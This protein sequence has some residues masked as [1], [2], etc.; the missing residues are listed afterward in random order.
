MPGFTHSSA[1]PIQT[2]SSPPRLLLLRPRPRAIQL[3]TSALGL[4]AILLSL[5]VI[6]ATDLSDVEFRWRFRPSLMPFKMEPILTGGDSCQTNMADCV[7]F[8]SFAPFAHRAPILSIWIWRRTG[9][10]KESLHCRHATEKRDERT[11]LIRSPHRHGRAA[12]VARSGR[13]PGQF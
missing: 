1:C 9:R 13:A 6:D 5:C 12:M 10:Y 3:S 11:P 4:S 7:H 2:R 8:D